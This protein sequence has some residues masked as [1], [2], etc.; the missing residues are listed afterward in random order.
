MPDDREVNKLFK[1]K[2]I[3]SRS[4]ERHKNRWEDDVLNDINR[5]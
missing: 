4:Q 2:P 1:W 5:Y 3:A